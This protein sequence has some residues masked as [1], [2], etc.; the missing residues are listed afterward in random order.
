[1]MTIMKLRLMINDNEIKD[2]DVVD[3]DVVD[4]KNV[5]EQQAIIVSV[6]ASS[7]SS[8]GSDDQSITAFG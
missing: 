4:E 5:S 2:N 8:Q 6:N 1:M 3:D 7:D